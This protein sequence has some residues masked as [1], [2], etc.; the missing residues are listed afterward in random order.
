MKES[1]LPAERIHTLLQPEP[2]LALVGLAAASW[3]LYRFLLREVSLERHRNLGRHFSGL[4]GQVLIFAG[5]F[6]LYQIL[7]LGPQTRMVAFLQPYLG[8]VTLIMGA[9][10][11]INTLRVMILEY[12]FLGHMKVGVPLLLVN[13]FTLLASLVVGAWMLTDIFGLRIAPLLATS[14]IFSVVLGLALQDTLGNLFAGV[15]LQIDKPYEIGHWIEV[16]SGT[17]R[18]VGQVHEISWRATVLLGLSDE[19]MTIPNRIM[20]QSQISNFSIRG[21]PFAR[22][23]AFR[24]AHGGDI[25][26][27]KK[28]LLKAIGG[29]TDVPAAPAPLV[30]VSETQ[31]S[32]I[33]LKLVYYLSDYGAQFRIQDRVLSAGLEALREAGIPAALQRHQVQTVQNPI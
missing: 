1:F 24:I 17:Q 25:E 12:L 7:D 27:A 6:A 28:A 16:Q 23:Q 18:W 32:G 19:L 22:S 9:V 29:V 31:D 4:F 2:A 30:L 15:A 3:L 20:G 10:I 21:E 26:I 8:L 5:I 11:F 13:I 33:T 14:A